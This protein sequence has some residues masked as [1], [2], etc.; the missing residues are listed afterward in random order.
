MLCPRYSPM[1]G[2]GLGLGLEGEG[3]GGGG[4]GGRRFKSLLHRNFTV[5]FLSIC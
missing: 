4:G 5:A 2:L 1:E 3:G